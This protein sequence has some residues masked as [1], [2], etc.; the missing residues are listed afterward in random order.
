MLLIGF[1]WLRTALVADPLGFAILCSKGS[2]RPAVE[3]SACKEL[4][5]PTRAVYLLCITEAAMLCL[6][7]GTPSPEFRSC[8]K[9]SDLAREESGGACE[10]C[11]IEEDA[12]RTRS[13]LI[14]LTCTCKE[15][16]NTFGNKRVVNEQ[17][18]Q[19]VSAHFVLDLYNRMVSIRT[20]CFK[21]IKKNLQPA[22]GVYLCF[23]R[24]LR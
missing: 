23:V 17:W 22:H 3:L 14:Q 2:I 16:F 21:V 15:G 12:S 19:V 24:F 11:S 18:E 5:W 9:Y 4:H 6:R 10:I 1:M 13:E 20:T 7:V 8:R